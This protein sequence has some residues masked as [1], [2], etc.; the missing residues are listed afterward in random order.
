MSA[1]KKTEY[2]IENYDL[3]GGSK[4]QKYHIISYHPRAQPSLWAAPQQL[5]NRLRVS[6]MPLEPS[7]WLCTLKKRPANKA[8]EHPA[9]APWPVTPIAGRTRRVLSPAL[10]ITTYD[11][12]SNKAK[13]HSTTPDDMFWKPTCLDIIEDDRKAAKVAKTTRR[14]GAASSAATTSFNAAGAASSAGTDIFRDPWG[15][16]LGGSFGSRY[17]SQ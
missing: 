14:A 2:H 3:S 12:P 1:N 13:R 5:L 9:T 11:S 8:A 7:P 4:F 15:G 16:S 17:F 10:G 6:V